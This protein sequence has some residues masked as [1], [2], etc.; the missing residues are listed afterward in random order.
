[1]L[2][3]FCLRSSPSGPALSLAFTN[4]L[5]PLTACRMRFAVQRMTCYLDGRT[6]SSSMSRHMPLPLWA[7]TT[8]TPSG[9]SC[10]ATDH[11]GLAALRPHPPS[12]SMEGFAQH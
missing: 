8:V 11:G 6:T 7:H 5:A 12:L 2:L 10:W 3:P 1:M 4:T 9:P